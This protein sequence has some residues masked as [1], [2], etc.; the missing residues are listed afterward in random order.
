[1]KE[2]EHEKY[3]KCGGNK[4]CKLCQPCNVVLCSLHGR[5]FYALTLTGYRLVYQQHLAALEMY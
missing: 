1:M 2:K 3:T 4:L 5:Q